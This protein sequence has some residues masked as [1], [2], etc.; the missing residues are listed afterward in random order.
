MSGTD[1]KSSWNQ[2]LLLPFPL[3]LP[4]SFSVSF[5]NLS[6]YLGAP[7]STLKHYVYDKKCWRAQLFNHTTKKKKD[8][9]FLLSTF[10]VSC[11]LQA[12]RSGIYITY[13]FI[14]SFAIRGGKSLGLV[15]RGVELVF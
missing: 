3:P 1:A 2:P 4:L 9:A 14:I 5:F 8:L 12:G 10:G 6:I 13:L 7:D 15:L 11:K